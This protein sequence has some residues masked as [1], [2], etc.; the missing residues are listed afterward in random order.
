MITEL[1]HSIDKNSQKVNEIALILNSTFEQ[2]FTKWNTLITRLNKLYD[3]VEKI[4]EF[5]NLLILQNSISAE[6][7]KNLRSEINLLKE[8]I[9]EIDNSPF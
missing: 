6:S 4:K 2:I 9:N 8:R 1:A 5:T 3:D 7:L